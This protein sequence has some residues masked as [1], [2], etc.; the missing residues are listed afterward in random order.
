MFLATDLAVYKRLTGYPLDSR[1]VPQTDQS[2]LPINREVIGPPDLN[3]YER[4]YDAVNK[5]FEPR[6]PTLPSYGVRIPMLRSNVQAPNGLTS[7]DPQSAQIYAQGYEPA[8]F[9]QVPVFDENVTGRKWTDVWPCVTFREHQIDQDPSTYVY[10]DPFRGPDPNAGVVSVKNAAGQVVSTGQAGVTTRPH[11]EAWSLIYVLTARAKKR[12][13]LSFIC[14][15]IMQLFPQKGALTVTQQDGSTHTC[16]MLLQRVVTLDE[17]QDE[18]TPTASPDEPRGFARAFVYKIETY[19]DNTTNQF[20][21]Q[22]SAWATRQSAVILDRLLEIDRIMGDLV[23]GGPKFNANDNEI[24]PF[25][26]SAD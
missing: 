7:Q 3:P 9:R 23:V 14:T 19:L 4:V 6:Y 24:Q 1:G 11:P 10:H 5:S 12:V 13:E 21:V 18:I 22:G 26:P 16:D 20:G 17:G 8:A 2:G 25:T 15:Q